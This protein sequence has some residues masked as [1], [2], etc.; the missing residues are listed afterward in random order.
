M[1]LWDTLKGWVTRDTQKYTYAPIP[2]SRTVGATVGATPVEAGRHYFR[3]WLSEMCLARDRAWFTEWHPAVHSLVRLQFGSTQAEL[4]NIAGQLSLPGIEPSNLDRVVAL[5]Y[6]LTALMPFNGGTIE[7]TAGL[8]A[9]KG[10]NL[11]VGMVGT[12]GTF[13]DLLVVPQLSAALAIAAPIAQGVESL[14]A[15]ANGALHLGLHQTFTGSGGGGGNELRPGYLV[16]VLAT[17]EQVP[18]E[19]LWVRDDRLHL[20][21]SVEELEPVTGY[22][23]MLFRV[24]VR[25]ERD[26]WEALTSINNPFNKAIEALGEQ[27]FERAETFRRVAVANALQSL[28][29]T[30]ADRIRISRAVNDTFLQA[31]EAGL[32]AVGGA[33]L[34]LSEAMARAPSAEEAIALGEPSYEELFSS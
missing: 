4:P 1:S 11:I 2:P 21:T 27:E 14:L 25:N 13:G 28:D 5:N 31:R 3:L 20:G 24:E 8:L 6:P 18:V 33:A 17:G 29:L 30:R 7:L 19:H 12:M 26:D 10:D 16:A 9:M 22:A 32:M 23:Y 34:T 15:G